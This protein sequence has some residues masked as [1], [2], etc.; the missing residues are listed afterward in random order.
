MQHRNEIYTFFFLYI[1][2]HARIFGNR[3]GS[4]LFECLGF[5]NTIRRLDC[6]D[7]SFR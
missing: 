3:L 4:L 5:D 7:F 6:K 2:F 1:Q